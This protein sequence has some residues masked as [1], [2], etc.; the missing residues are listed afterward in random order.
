MWVTFGGENDQLLEER[1]CG[2]SGG[3]G[4]NLEEHCHSRVSLWKRSTEILPFCVVR[5]GRTTMKEGACIWIVHKKP[6]KNGE[7]AE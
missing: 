7:Q 2:T 5:R 1:E 4:C 3:V 6:F